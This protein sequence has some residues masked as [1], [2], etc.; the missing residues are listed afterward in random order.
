MAK[1]PVKNSKVVETKAKGPN[2]KKRNAMQRQS[3]PKALKIL[4]MGSGCY[5]TMLKAWQ[6]S[7]R[8]APAKT[9]AVAKG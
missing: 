5:K 1:K 2:R 7:H 4:C 3:L 8:K 6:E 9:V